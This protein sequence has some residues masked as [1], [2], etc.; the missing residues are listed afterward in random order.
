MKMLLNRCKVCNSEREGDEPAVVF[1]GGRCS[2]I[3]KA[4]GDREHTDESTISQVL[5]K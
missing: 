4:K 5:S 3:P 1:A 2:K